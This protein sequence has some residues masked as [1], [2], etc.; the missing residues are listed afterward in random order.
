[1]TEDNQGTRLARN[2]AAPQQ[3]QAARIRAVPTMLVGILFISGPT[4]CGRAAHELDVAP[5]QGRA[6][7]DGSPLKSGVVF[8]M[9]KRGRSA[10]GM[11]DRD[12]TFTLTT[13][14]E[15][16]GAQI[17]TH[18]V[19]VTPVPADELDRKGRADRVPLP[20][21]YSSPKTSGLEID[22]ISGETNEVELRLV[23]DAD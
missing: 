7:L 18:P 6:L 4:G 15:G 19:V 1:M 22:V 9:P 8:V 2:P 16:D 10:R 5:V 12:G 14:R 13:Y 3:G 23:S 11:I 21:R 17:G 20:A